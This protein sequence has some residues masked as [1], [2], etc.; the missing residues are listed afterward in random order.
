[1]VSEEHIA[2]VR[3]LYALT[4]RALKGAAVVVDVTERDL[5]NG[6]TVV[7]VDGKEVYRVVSGSPKPV[8]GQTLLL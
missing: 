2:V 5:D 3:A 8:I 4:V 1:M 7:T 6:D